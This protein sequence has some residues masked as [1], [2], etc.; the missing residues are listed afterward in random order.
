MADQTPTPLDVRRTRDAS[1]SRLIAIL[2]STTDLV[3]MTDCAGRT[4]YV[5]RA[6]RRMLGWSDDEATERVHLSEI[7]PPWAYAIVSEQ[8]LP[9]AF[10]D[11][12]WSGESAL[13]NRTGR[14]IPVLQVLL[15]HTDAAGNVEFYSTTCRDISD[16]KQKELEQIE[17]SNRYDAAIRAS[18]RVMFDWD[19][20]TGKIDYAGAIER[21]T[22][23]SPFE[24][25][26]GLE[27][28]RRL[29]HVEDRKKFDAA[30]QAT[31]DTRDPLQVEFELRRK[32][33]RIIV[34]NADGHF[35]LDRLG[36]IGRMV[37]FLSDITA[38]KA[39]ERGVQSTQE[40]LEHSVSERTRELE[41]ANAE[42]LE[43]AR[44]QE[45]VAR[46]GQR[47][48]LGIPLPELMNEAVELVRSSLQT[49]CASLNEWRGEFQTLR[50]RASIGWPDELSPD[51]TSPGSLSQSGY[52][53]TLG[54]PV[55]S[56]DYEQESRFTPSNSCRLTGIRCGVTVPIVAGAMRFGVLGAFAKNKREFG[57]DDISFMLGVG[58]IL[59][60]AIE[61]LHVEQTAQ[62]A[63]SE[64]ES[65]NRAKSEFLSRMSHELRTPLNAILGFTQLL[66]LEVQDERNAESIRYISQAGHNL[67]E[68]I[69]EVL[70]IARLDSGRVEFRHEPVE[71]VTLITE[72]VNATRALAAKNEITFVVVN[73]DYD[74]PIVT[75]DRERLKQI[76]L[77]L[78]SNAVKYNRPG[79]SVTIATA[80]KGGDRWKI[81]VTDTG[82]GIAPENLSRLFVPFERLGPKEGGT[83]GGTGLGLALC[84]RLA[85]ALKGDIGVGSTVGIG[86]TFWIELPAEIPE[87]KN[88]PH[89]PSNTKT[90]PETNTQT[91]KTILYVE[92]DLANFHLIER[93]IE[94]RKCLKLISASEGR[95]AMPLALE[96]QPSLILLDL[97]LPDATGEE[98]I[99]QIKAETTTQNIPVI[100][101]TGEVGGDRVNKVL[102]LGA[103]DMLEK[104]Y[105]VQTFLKLLDTYLGVA[106]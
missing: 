72:C 51:E 32:D 5:N 104:P 11:G 23:Y 63:Q 62:F 53:I 22:G 87:T 31:L 15:A 84:Q 44:Q 60:A 83:A 105:R 64:A 45:A 59:S 80:K 92:D 102:T 40:R 52:T 71:L 48:L 96:H 29:I 95:L 100:V 38:E 35:F 61:R 30:I 106:T 78:F 99:A 89:G 4:L 2:E 34:I 75:T 73:P 20:T 18:G 94:T 103:V 19:S 24:L 39:F 76:F 26:G 8:G 70:D 79:G 90:P 54:A 91:M 21:V 56:A 81:S 17:W 33:G 50:S 7:F 12:S 41:Q 74:A 9:S 57:R 58:N 85:K 68:L 3:L 86:S 88:L 101:V 49:D 97:N 1:P 28:L 46:L 43:S 14:E 55:V 82:A 66:E 25:S 37:G 69:N 36:R 16:R 42:L 67:L 98:I 65:A 93:I 47:A 13:L 27:Q 77:N 6:G 10:S